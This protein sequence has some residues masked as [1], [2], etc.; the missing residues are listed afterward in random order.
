MVGRCLKRIADA[1]GVSFQFK[2][3][4]TGLPGKDSSIIEIAWAF[5]D[6]FKNWERDNGKLNS[7]SEESGSIGWG[8]PAA[9]FIDG[10]L[11]IT[12]GMVLVN[13][14]MEGSPHTDIAAIHEITMLHELCHALNL[15]HVDDKREVMYPSVVEGLPIQLGNGDRTGLFTLTS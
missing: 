12:G 2:G 11:T 1:T 7:A 6:E 15:G 8:G 14:E 9:S 13:A 10:E 4:F 3:T 5:D